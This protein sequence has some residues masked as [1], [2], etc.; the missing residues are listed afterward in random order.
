MAWLRPLLQLLLCG[1]EGSEEYPWY[2]GD[3]TG[4]IAAMIGGYPGRQTRAHSEMQIAPRAQDPFG[5][6]DDMMMQPFG[7]PAGGGMF[8]SMFGQMNRMMQEMDT[9]MSRGGMMGPDMLGGGGQSSMMMSSM[10]GG[11]GGSFSCQTFSFSSRTGPDGQVHTEQ[12]S[13]SAVGDRAQNM[14]E[15]QQMYSN[16]RT[17]EDKMSWGVWLDPLILGAV[18]VFRPVIWRCLDVAGLLGNKRSAY[19]VLA[20]LVAY[21]CN[22]RRTRSTGEERQTDMF[23]GM[24]ENDAGDFDQDW[25]RRAVPALPQHQQGFQRMMLSDHSG[26]GLAGREAPSNR[27]PMQAALP[28]SSG[29][30]YERPAEA[31]PPSSGYRSYERP[32]AQSNYEPY[33]TRPAPQTVPPRRNYNGDYR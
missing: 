33:E 19:V 2:R 7:G 29:Y 20:R 11:G 15:V 30:G 8:G 31:R 25:Q 6:L 32:V 22:H 23:R 18:A 27:R 12:F 17:G 10:G 14:H 26:H 5:M 28:S 21:T 1:D 16:S 4:P 3:S 9:M 13:S 24:S